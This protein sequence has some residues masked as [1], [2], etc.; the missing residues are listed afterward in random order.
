MT[1]VRRRSP[2][3]ADL[4]ILVLGILGFVLQSVRSLTTGRRKRGI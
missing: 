2:L 3:W 1:A 4:R